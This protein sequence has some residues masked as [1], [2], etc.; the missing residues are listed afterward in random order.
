MGNMTKLLDRPLKAFAIY[1]LLILIIS[2]P[3]YFF[4]VDFIWLE[5]LDEQNWL[6][7]EHT[8][9]RLQ[10][11]QLKAEEIDK[12]DEIWGSLQ[13]GASITPWDSTLARKD[14]IYEIMRPNEFDL[15]NGMDRFRGLQ[16]FVSINGHPYR[17]TIETNVEEADETL[18]AIALVTFFFFIL[19]LIGL[20]YLN[21]R[22]ALSTWKPFKKI[23]QTLQSFDLS[24]DEK[25]ELPETNIYEFEELNHVLRTLVNK[26]IST[27]QQQK[28]FTENASHELQTPIALLKSRLDL[29]LQEKE[30]SPQISELL[31]GIEAPLSRLSRINKNLLLLAK[32]ENHQ[33]QSQERIDIK[34]SVENALSLFEDYFIDKRLSI[35]TSLD[36]TKHINANAFLLET[37]IHNLLSNAVRH[38]PF[39]GNIIITVKDD[40]LLIA[41]SGAEA[42]NS[43]RLF[44]RFSTVTKERIGSG[45]GL[46]IVKEVTNKYGWCI[47]YRFQDDFHS[48]SVSF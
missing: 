22:I 2:I 43:Q 34:T 33:Y 38:T 32:V 1:S 26:N 17:I 24:R 8:K 44:K 29:L 46:A 36:E 42:L 40:N 23:L 25:I 15:E 39:G 45:L 12:L 47:V 9:R 11:L 20:I 37:L 27:Y 3:A 41:N 30:V 7:L 18:F 28:A 48:F 19:L 35:K 16:S 13:P 21:K 4:V 31:G 5:E 6:T 14:S 10:N